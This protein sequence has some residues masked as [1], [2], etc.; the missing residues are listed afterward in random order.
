MKENFDELFCLKR[1]TTFIHADDDF[2]S[3]KHNLNAPD[4]GKLY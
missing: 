4:I 2:M 3:S 1:K